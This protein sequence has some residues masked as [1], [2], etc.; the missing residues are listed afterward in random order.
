ME[1]PFSNETIDTLVL[2]QFEDVQLT[3]LHPSYLKVIWFNIALVFGIIA[4]AAGFGFYYINELQPYRLAISVA[5]IFIVL[6]TIVINVINFKTRGFAFREHDV[7]Y[8]SGAISINTTIIPYNRV[9]HVATH[10]SLVARW[11]DLATIEVFTAGGVGGDIKIPGL[12]KIHAAAIKQLVVGKID[13]KQAEDDE[14][15]FTEVTKEQAPPKE[16]NNY[17]RD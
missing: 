2:P 9:Q 6:L 7:I 13:A 3:P 5:Y 10:E 4:I 11:L 14:D 12:E 17:E 15:I 16:D 1:Q 8:R